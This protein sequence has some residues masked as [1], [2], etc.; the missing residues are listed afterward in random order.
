M[1]LYHT[2]WLFRKFYPKDVL[3][4]IPSKDKI[5]YLTF[6]D[7]PTTEITE[8]ILEVLDAHNAKATFFCVGENVAKNPEI[9]KSIIEK[10]HTVGNHTYNHLN[11][12]QTGLVD[13]VENTGKAKDLVKS[14][15]FRPPY[16]KIKRSQAR[17]L[18]NLGYDIIL[19]TVLTYDFDKNLDKNEAWEKIVKYSKPGSILVFHD[20][21]KAFE[22]LKELLS[23]TLTYF[24]SQ[25]YKFE[26]ISL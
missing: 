2:P 6:D 21:V 19:W 13:Y 26:K 4:Q 10:G 16:G 17:L 23:K 11:G 15:L 9:Y 22:N 12:W 8:W 18:N 14:N 3:W 1:R 24:T 25:G 7:G 5:L 20:H